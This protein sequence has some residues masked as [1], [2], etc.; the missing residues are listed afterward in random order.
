MPLDRSHCLRTCF[1][2]SSGSRRFLVRMPAAA[3]Q[4]LGIRGRGCQTPCCLRI[5]TGVVFPIASSF[6][7]TAK[8]GTRTAASPQMIDG[9]GSITS[10]QTSISTTRGG[11][12]PR[13]FTNTSGPVGHNVCCRLSGQQGRAG[14]YYMLLRCE[15]LAEE[16]RILK[17]HIK[18]QLRVTDAERR[19]LAESGHRLGR[20]LLNDVARLAKPDQQKA[21][22][23]IRDAA[24]ASFSPASLRLRCGEPSSEASAKA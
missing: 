13:L 19:S 23:T 8:R 4:L 2:Y 11:D 5:S 15:Y 6:P 18:G 14:G 16:N 9:Y 12:P 17:E 10:I 24:K 22:T 20:K 7:Q 3:F 1:W 21:L